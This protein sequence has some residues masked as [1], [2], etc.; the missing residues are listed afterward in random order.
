MSLNLCQ[1]HVYSFIGNSNVSSE[2]LWQD[3]LR[4]NNSGRGAL[5]NNYVVTLTYSYFLDPFFTL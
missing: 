5:L 2:N 1:K 4:L 3:G